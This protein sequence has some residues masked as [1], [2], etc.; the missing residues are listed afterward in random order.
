MA[1]MGFTAQ[2]GIQ[3]LTMPTSFYLEMPNSDVM[4]FRGGVFVSAEDAAKAGGDISADMIPACDVVTTIHV[5]P[6]SHLNV[7]H[8]ALWDH[9]DGLG[10]SKMMPI[11]EI[12][13]DDPTTV[14][15]AE[16]RTEIYR[17]IG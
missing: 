6:Y 11:W 13:V 9:M 15:E 2:H 14:P 3:P 5:G 8:K 16:C 12:Y 7:S 1:V 17:V 10:L 4:T